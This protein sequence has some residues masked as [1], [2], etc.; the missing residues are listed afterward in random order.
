LT[1]LDP[2]K[3]RR[4]HFIPIESVAQGV[5]AAQKEHGRDMRTLVVPN[6]KVV[7]PLLNG[8]MKTFNDLGG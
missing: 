8:K 1:D 2:D 5:E 6:G 4:I 7:L 3:L